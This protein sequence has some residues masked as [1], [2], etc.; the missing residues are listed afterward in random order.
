VAPSA[1]LLEAAAAMARERLSA[2]LVVA[3][4]I[5]VG[6]VTERDILRAWRRRLNA[7][8]RVDA[9]MGRPVVGCAADC[10]YREAY[11]LLNRKRIHHLAIVDAAGRA[12]GLVSDGAFRA[13][14]DMDADG[15]RVRVA[16]AMTPDPVAIPLTADL[17]TAVIL[18]ERAG[19][20]AAGA[21]ADELLGH[22]HRPRRGTRVA[23][24]GG[25]CPLPIM[26][27][28][29]VTVGEEQTSVMPSC[30]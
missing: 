21:E 5:A 24:A 23:A 27:A 2:V 19:V 25:A 28:P 13:N 6:I 17:D 15:A 29:V 8:T 26:T 16:T 12:V 20:T 30:R 4:G 14:L 3:A 22:R 9:V 11:R 1:A 18:M 7:A 10:D